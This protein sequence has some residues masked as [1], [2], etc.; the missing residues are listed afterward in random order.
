MTF[1]FRLFKSCTS[2]RLMRVMTVKYSCI[3]QNIASKATAWNSP[4]T[5]SLL[6]VR[7]DH[8]Y[9]FKSI[10]EDGFSSTCGQNN[11]FL[12]FS[13]GH[14][15]NDQKVITISKFTSVISGLMCLDNIQWVQYHE[16]WNLVIFQN[17]GSTAKPAHE[18]PLGASSL[19]K[20][21]PDPRFSS[22]KH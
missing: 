18:D 22:H 19:L 20:P 11:G 17:K 4:G 7:L 13:D 12:T 21:R 14:G 10:I 2:S 16:K 9:N 1:W 8:K 15:P 5:S 6:K 3:S